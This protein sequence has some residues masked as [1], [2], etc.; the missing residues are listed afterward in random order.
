MEATSVFRVTCIDRLYKKY[1]LWYCCYPTIGL[2]LAP[3]LTN[4]NYFSMKKQT[5]GTKLQLKKKSITSLN[6]GGQSI[7]LGGDVVLNPGLGLGSNKH[8]CMEPTKA[9]NSSPCNNNTCVG[10]TCLYLN[11][12]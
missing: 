10:A 7:I 8:S 5:I 1:H 9:G 12:C 11:G 2:S 3:L 6:V 4:L